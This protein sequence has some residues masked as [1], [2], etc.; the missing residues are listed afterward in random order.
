VCVA[1]GLAA[2]AVAL[3]PSGSPDV[4]ARAAAALNDPDTILHLKSVDAGGNT[5]ETWQAD[6]GRKE[7]WLYRGGTG[8]AVESTEDWDTKTA[9]SYSAQNDELIT[10]TEPDFFNKDSRVGS[11][12]EGGPGSHVYDDLALLLDRA[13]AG[14][15]NVHLSGETTGRDIPVYELRIDYTMEVIDLPA[16][17]VVTDPTGLPTHT[18]QLHRTVYISRDSYLPVR[19]V[20]HLPAPGTRTGSVE[21]TTDYLVAERVERT[22]ETEALLRMTPHPGAK[23]VIEGRF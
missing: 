2:F 23:K 11:L 9:L 7:R 20:E 22:P 18:E 5:M 12:S 17:G 4:I 16:S 1:A 8:K 3:L 19:I 10:H 14:A 13:R 15:G 6:G 21:A